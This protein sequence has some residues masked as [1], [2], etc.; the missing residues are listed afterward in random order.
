MDVI[1][2]ILALTPQHKTL[3]V[4]G[5]SLRSIKWHNEFKGETA[6]GEFDKWLNRIDSIH[7]IQYRYDPVEDFYYFRHRMQL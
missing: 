3:A 5:N 2:E 1:K 7:K 4:T 6:K